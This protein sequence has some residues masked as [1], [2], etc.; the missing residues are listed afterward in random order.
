MA[1]ERGLRAE[2][3]GTPSEIVWLA[4]SSRGA[5]SA[6]RG[7]GAG[8]QIIGATSGRDVC[9]QNGTLFLSESR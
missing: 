7:C 2:I 6:M 5:Q 3:V 4:W 1:P 8:L 9:A